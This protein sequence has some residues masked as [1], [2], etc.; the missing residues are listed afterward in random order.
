[1]CKFHDI[2]LSIFLNFGS[3]LVA[4]QMTRFLEPALGKCKGIAKFKYWNRNYL[5]EGRV[6]E[7]SRIPETS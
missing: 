5:W 2:A 7:T 4:H 1:L 3:A 6:P